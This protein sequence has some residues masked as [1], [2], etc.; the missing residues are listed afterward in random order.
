VQGARDTTLILTKVQVWR[1]KWMCDQGDTESRW[2]THRHLW[3]PQGDLG[4]RN[5]GRLPG[6]SDAKIEF[7]R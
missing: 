3:E 7:E 4:R 1:R 2:R 5:Q 6:G